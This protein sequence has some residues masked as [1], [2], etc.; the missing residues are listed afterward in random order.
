MSEAEIKAVVTRLADLARVLADADPN[1]KS[2]IF[3]QLGLRLTYHPGRHLVQAQIEAPRHWY[4][5]SV[6]G[7]T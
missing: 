7:G 4:F 1:D 5:E 6:R 3:R 2:E